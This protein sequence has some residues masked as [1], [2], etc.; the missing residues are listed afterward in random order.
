M[1]RITGIG[2]DIED[3]NRFKNIGKTKTNKLTRKIFT[4]NEIKYCFSKKNPCPSL[5]ARFCGKEAVVKAFSHHN[6]KIHLTQIEILNKPNGIPFVRLLNK[7]SNRFDIQISLSHSK[8]IAIAF[9]IVS[10]DLEDK[11]ALKN[12]KN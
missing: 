2:V 12:D 8:E 10:E 6:I 9:A 7:R 1:S 3:V 11:G 4:D 5:A